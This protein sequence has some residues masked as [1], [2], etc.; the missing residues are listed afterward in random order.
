MAEA[1]ARSARAIHDRVVLLQSLGLLCESV[2]DDRRKQYLMGRRQHLKV[3]TQL[4]KFGKS[5][6]G[7]AKSLS[8]RVAARAALSI[9]SVDLRPHGR[10]FP[11]AGS[12]K[13]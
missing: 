12:G 1:G 9:H 4:E 10:P 8:C 5:E 3:L 2:A 7:A 6:E 11:E 13:R